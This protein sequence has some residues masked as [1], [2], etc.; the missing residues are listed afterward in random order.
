MNCQLRAYCVLTDVSLTTQLCVS[1]QSQLRTNVNVLA[2]H[3]GIIANGAQRMYPFC[4]YTITTRSY[5]FNM[6]TCVYAFKMGGASNFRVVDVLYARYAA[7]FLFCNLNKVLYG[8]V[9]APNVHIIKEHEDS[10]V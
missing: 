9:S 2:D 10:S 8:L 6:H 7:L 4:T 5:G 3:R 1:I